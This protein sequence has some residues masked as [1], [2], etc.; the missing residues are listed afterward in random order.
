MKEISGRDPFY[1]IDEISGSKLLKIS[2]SLTEENLK[3]QAGNSGPRLKTLIDIARIHP[4]ITF[5]GYI[6]GKQRNDE[7]LSIDG[8]TFPTSV[9]TQVIARLNLDKEA[10]KP[11]ENMPEKGGKSRR[12]WWD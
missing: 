9:K 2:K 6:I 5:E 1:R 12:Y 3:N 4:D 8:M 7:R 10:R 11:D